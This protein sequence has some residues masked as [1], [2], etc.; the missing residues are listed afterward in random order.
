MRMDI[1][2]K[3]WTLDQAEAIDRLAHDADFKVFMQILLSSRAELLES[4]SHE[5]RDVEVRFLQGAAQ[6]AEAVAALVG[7][8]SDIVKA[9][10]QRYRGS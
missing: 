9:V 10:R 1:S 4:L 3:N 7:S 5:T 6:H 2:T 8:S